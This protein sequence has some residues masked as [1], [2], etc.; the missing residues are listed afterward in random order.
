M[1]KKITTI[2]LAIIISYSIFYLSLYSIAFNNIQFYEAAFNKYGIYHKFVN[3]DINKINANVLSYLQNNKINLINRFF[4]NK[5]RQHLKDVQE[6]FSLFNKVFK[7]FCIIFLLLVCLLF[8][9][10]S[11]IKL[12]FL[13]V[14]NSFI[15]G[16]ILII[17]LILALGL[18]IY[19]DFDSIFITMHNIFFKPDSWIFNFDENIVN[20][21]VEDF[22]Y[23]ISIYLVKTILII[24]SGIAILSLII[25]NVI[26]IFK[27]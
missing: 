22:F 11:N 1:Y 25:K 6:L 10:S 17:G 9:T 21:Y 3:H 8:F 27:R 19:F 14:I 5:E 20:L 7:I 18:L 23:D 4:N 12:F 15:A 2:I 16:S 24:A 13:Q 26:G